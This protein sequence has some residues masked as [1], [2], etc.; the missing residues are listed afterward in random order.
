MAQFREGRTRKVM[1]R[2]PVERKRSGPPWWLW[3][4]LGLLLLGL[5]WFLFELFDN[6]AN[7]VD[8]VVVTTPT[9]ETVA[10]GSASPSPTPSPTPSPSPTPAASATTDA[11]DT[12]TDPAAIVLIPVPERPALVGRQVLIETVPVQS[13]PGDRT[14]L[15]GE[16]QDQPLLVVLDE[17]ASPG[18]TEGQVDV[19]PGQTVSII[20]QVQALPPSAEERQALGLDDAALAQIEDDQ[21]YVLASDVAIVE[22]AA[23]ASPSPSASP[24]TA[25]SPS[26]SAS[27]STA[28]G[29]DTGPLTDIAVIVGTAE[30]A[31]LVGR[32]LALEGV[33][34]QRVTGD[35]TFWV[36]P[37]DEAQQVLVVLNEI[38]TPSDSDTEGRYDVNPGQTINLFGEVREFPGLEALQQ[39]FNI[40]AENLDEI[41]AQPIYLF[42][43]RLEIVERP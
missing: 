25:A 21:V 19:N 16:D 6:D 31:T 29:G 11:G 3:P 12:I 43:E 4:L 28:A 37:E 5:L 8:P 38:P 40:T 30:P 35:V 42:A 41:A 1:A 15:V 32:E 36:G 13:V 33:T 23:A 14:F 22:Q 26:P 39:E 20:G 17:E 18:A 34:V 7:P 27:P 10:G 2:I 9:A 24:S